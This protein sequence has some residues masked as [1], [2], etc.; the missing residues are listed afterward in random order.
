MSEPTPVYMLALDLSLSRLRRQFPFVTFKHGYQ[1]ELSKESKIRLQEWA[2]QDIENGAPEFRKIISRAKLLER[3]LLSAVFEPDLEKMR[4]LFSSLVEFLSL[5]FLVRDAY[6]ELSERI[7]SSKFG[8]DSPVLDPVRPD[9]MSEVQND[10]EFY[11]KAWR[12]LSIPDTVRPINRVI[13]DRYRK[14]YEEIKKLM[15]IPLPPEVI[16]LYLTYLYVY[17]EA[18][19]L[20]HR[21]DVAA[22]HA[23]RILYRAV[24]YFGIRPVDLWR[25]EG[26]G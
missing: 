20:A 6:G 26:E 25:C 16:I 15:D 9:M 22:F 2:K 12:V 14:K 10:P 1:G 8:N 19:A 24:R 3:R 23:D 18:V 11:S 4:E 17:E 7:L 13:Q 5:K 21:E